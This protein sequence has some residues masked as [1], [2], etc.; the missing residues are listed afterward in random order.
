MR[1]YDLGFEKEH[2][3]VVTPNT[4]RTVANKYE[5]LKTELEEYSSIADITMSSG[6]PGFNFGGDNYGEAGAPVEAAIGLFELFADYNYIDFFKLE[7]ISGRNFDPKLGTDAGIP[8]SENAPQEVMAILNEEAVR[9]F[10]WA[11]PEEAIGKKIY[12]DPNA[13][14]WAANV[15]GV[16]KDF[17]MQSLQQ[18]I[19]PTIIILR[20][21]YNYLAIKLNP[22]DVSAGIAAVEKQVKSFSPEADFDYAFLD[23][24]FNQQYLTEQRLSKAF[25]QISLLA[26]LIACMGLFG[27]A[28]F[29]T[30]QRI[31][32]IGVRKTLGASLMN[33]VL[34]LSKDF[35]K[36]VLIA[37]VIAI[38][39]SYF[40]T[41]RGLENFA[42]RINLRPEIYLFALL[43]ALSIAFLTVSFHTLKAAMSNPVKSLRTE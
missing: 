24:N 38:P 18:E 40:I 29:S 41:E 2:V 26:I 6:L 31:K 1:S 11:S 20:P 3:M 15:I 27:L 13:K 9:Q 14:D 37:V 33:I 10:G 42:Y 7:L 19:S 21:I 39:I 36:L 30:T 4:A 17:H 43:I 12:R 23:E 34:L 22:G 8:A 35:T 16:V 5:T 28:A 25:T 32:E